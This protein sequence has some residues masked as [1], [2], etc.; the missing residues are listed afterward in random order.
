MPEELVGLPY[1]FVEIPR[2]VGWFALTI[3]YRITEELVG[4]PLRISQGLP[5]EF[6]SPP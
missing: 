5:E 3:S 1:D 2:E 6:A 4:P